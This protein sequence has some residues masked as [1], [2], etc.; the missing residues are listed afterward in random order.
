MSI[1][2]SRWRIGFDI[3]GTFTDFILY[4]GEKR[5]LVPAQGADVGQGPL[6]R[7]AAGARRAGRHAPASAS[8][9]SPRSCTAP[10]SSPTP[11]SSAQGADARP[12]HHRGLPRHPGDGHRAALRHLRPVPAV[13]GAARRRATGGSKSPSASTRDGRVITRARCGRGASAP[14]ARW[15]PPA[16]TAIAVSFLNA[17]AN[18]T[19]ERQ[20]A[21]A[22]RKLFPDVCRLALQRRRRR[23][24]RVPAHRHHVRERLR[25]A[26]DGPL[27]RQASRRRSPRAASRAR[28]G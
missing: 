15:W 8:P 26:A 9:T 11:S 12:D 4:D 2:T 24:G 17:Y 25:A 18:P 16:C 5:E 19:H 21:R 3:G 1:A 14:V 23:D 20:A 27:S 13:P 22:L 7:G 6:D 28:C 10:R